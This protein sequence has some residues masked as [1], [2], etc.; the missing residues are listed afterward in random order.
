M[1]DQEL[2]LDFLE[3]T[4]RLN[5]SAD[6]DLHY[7]IFWLKEDRFLISQ[8]KELRSG[9]PQYMQKE[10]YTY[11]N[12]YQF[13][14]DK[15][16]EL[17]LS[18]MNLSFLPDTIQNFSELRKLHLSNNILTYIP[19]SI[20]EL[21]NLNTLNLSNNQLSN[22]PSQLGS[23][24]KL[25][26]LNLS[27]NQLSELPEAIGNLKSLKELDLTQNQ[28]HELPKSL[29]NLK[30]LSIL[31]LHSNPLPSQITQYHESEVNQILQNL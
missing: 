12:N 21:Q 17:Y 29:A 9:K 4:N 27:Q 10:T 14:D 5:L 18:K 31:R 19:E 6:P 23:L 11:S 1:G 3:D 24:S 26:I 25:E 28:I 7:T 22:L 30:S 15:L 2:L 8:D 16:I 13:E 20:S